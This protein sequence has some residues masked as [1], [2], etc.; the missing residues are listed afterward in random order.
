MG[1]L[2]EMIVF[3]IKMTAGPAGIGIHPVNNLLVLSNSNNRGH[4]LRNATGRRKWGQ[5]CNDVYW[6]RYSRA[7]NDLQALPPKDVLPARGPLSGVTRRL[8]PVRR[9]L[10]LSSGETKHS[11]RWV[12]SRTAVPVIFSLI[13]TATVMSLSGFCSIALSMRTPITASAPTR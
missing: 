10:T 7:S 8:A 5:S 12:D 6:R 11:Y 4:I 1:L 9:L 3:A 13:A 2:N